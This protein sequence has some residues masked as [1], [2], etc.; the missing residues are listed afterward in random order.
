MCDWRMF[1]RP[2]WTLHCRGHLGVRG[3]WTSY[4]IYYFLVTAVRS[5][6]ATYVS[7]AWNRRGCSDST[8]HY[9]TQEKASRLQLLPSSFVELFKTTLTTIYTFATLLVC[10][11]WAEPNKPRVLIQWRKGLQL[12]VRSSDAR[13]EGGGC[14]LITNFGILKWRGND[15]EKKSERSCLVS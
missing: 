6:P 7:N 2:Q 11:R 9:Y 1:H 14:A 15:L 5:V 12:R 8:Q 3:C 10:H 4:C 13:G